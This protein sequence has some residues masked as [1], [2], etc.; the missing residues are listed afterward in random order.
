MRKN[1]FFRQAFTLVELV[2][3]LGITAILALIVL[4][5]L[6]NSQSQQ[7]F[8]NKFEE[9]LALVKEARSLAITGKGELDYTDADK[10]GIY[11]DHCDTPPAPSPCTSPDFATPANYGV[12]FSTLGATGQIK[13][14]ADIYP[15]AVSP[16]GSKDSFEEGIKNTDYQSGK[17]LVFKKITLPNTYELSVFKKS[18]ENNPPALSSISFFFSPLYADLK[19]QGSTFINE[20]P[21]LII[22]MKETSGVH[23]CREITIHQMA[24]V[25][26]VSN[27]P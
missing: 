24:G 6:L 25:P 17:D 3:V 13:L 15:P 16:L 10:D 9:V 12:N 11:D 22:R 5:G 26:E 2:I 18:Q 7:V 1:K 8:N 21:M 4:G 14:F 19:F 27:C 23:R 20:M